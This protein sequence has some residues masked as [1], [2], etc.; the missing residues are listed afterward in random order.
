V[1]ALPMPRGLPIVWRPPTSTLLATGAGDAL[2]MAL[3]NDRGLYR[4]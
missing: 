4:P 1:L 3:P 2:A